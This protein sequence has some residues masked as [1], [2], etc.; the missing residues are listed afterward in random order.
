MFTAGKKYKK[1]RNL[2][3]KLKNK[4]FKVKLAKGKKKSEHSISARQGYAPLGSGKQN[5]VVVFSL[6]PL[7]AYVQCITC[8][9][10]NYRTYSIYGNP[11]NMRHLDISPIWF[12]A[13]RNY[14]LVV[15]KY[16]MRVHS[17]HSQYNL[18]CTLCCFCAD[19][20]LPAAELESN[21]EDST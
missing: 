9:A 17:G 12:V 8:A 18:I 7:A 19:Q 6:Q 2:A 11:L 13:K 20:E 5:I 21:E 16:G 1:V 4:K 14:F 10:Y 15:R 3:G